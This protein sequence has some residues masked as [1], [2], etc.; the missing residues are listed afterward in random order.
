MR[1]RWAW[2]DRLT[3]KCHKTFPQR[4]F[5]S[6]SGFTQHDNTLFSLCDT[7]PVPEAIASATLEA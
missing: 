4:R 5:D 2:F 6:A 3:T 1:R 7:Y